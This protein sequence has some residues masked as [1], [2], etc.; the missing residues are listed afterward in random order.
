MPQ[1]TLNRFLVVYPKGVQVAPKSA[2]E[3]V[4]AMPL[5]QRLVPL[6]L[7]PRL[8]MGTSALATVFAAVKH[9]QDFPASRLFKLSGL[10]IVLAN[11]GPLSGAATVQAPKVEP[12]AKLLNHRNRSLASRR[13][14]FPT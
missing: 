9:W 1:Y 2:P 8:L 11:I 7:V 10:P 3:G 12:Q 14:G 6:E 4:P 13:F 5:G